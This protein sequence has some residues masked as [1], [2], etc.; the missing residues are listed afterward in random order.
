MTTQQVEDFEIRTD[1][2]Y[3]IEAHLWINVLESGNATVGVDS[4]GLETFGTLAQIAID[5]PP[6][7]LARGVQ[8]GSM[9]AEKFVG[10]LLSPIS[11]TLVRRNEAV[12]M[13][14]GLVERDPYGEGWLIEVEIEDDPV[15]MPYLVSGVEAVTEAFE[16][17]VAAYRLE[18]VLAE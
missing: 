8:F 9:E 10:T 14:P 1:F 17:R 12:L 18:G 15:T 3:D 13:D 6:V 2:T 5:E 4:L 16:K 7:A 11:G